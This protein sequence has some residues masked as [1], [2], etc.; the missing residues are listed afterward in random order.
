MIYSSVQIVVESERDRSAALPVKLQDTIQRISPKID[1]TIQSLKTLKPSEEVLFCPLTLNIPDH[2]P[3]LGQKT[4]EFCRSIESLQQSVSTWGYAIGEGK[5]WLPIILSPKGP[6]YAE[7]IQNGNQTYHQP[8]HLG[9]RTRQT[10]YQLGYQ[11]LRHIQAIPGVYLLQFGGTSDPCFD[12][13]IPFPDT[14]VLASLGVQ[15]PDLL[16]SYWYC[17]IG[18]PLI[19]LQIKPL[20]SNSA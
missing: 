7:A 5:N 2:L 17:Q 16:T 8:L 1:T 14:P 10:L 4:Y 6:L 11:L 20:P 15:E 19:D 9:D 3:F 13:L 12:R 18:T